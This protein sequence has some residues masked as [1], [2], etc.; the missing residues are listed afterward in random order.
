MLSSTK[1]ICNDVRVSEGKKTKLKYEFLKISNDILF[2][3][4]LRERSGVDSDL[5]LSD[6][7]RFY[8]KEKVF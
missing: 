4:N 7:E 6:S 3:V 2:W 1:R 8:L 5:I